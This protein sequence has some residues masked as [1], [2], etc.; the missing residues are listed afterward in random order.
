MAAVAGHN[1]DQAG[2]AILASNISKYIVPT[3]RTNVLYPVLAYMPDLSNNR[4]EKHDIPQWGTLATPANQVEADEYAFSNIPL[5][6][7]RTI[8]AVDPG[9]RALVTDQVVMDTGMSS[10]ASVNQHIEALRQHI[11]KMMFDLIN[12]ATNITDE[13]GNAL[14]LT[15][16]LDGL[17]AFK[18]QKPLGLQCFVGS[19]DQ[20]NDFVKEL[21]ASGGSPLIQGAGSEVFAG[22]GASYDGYR[23][24]YAGVRIFETANVQ[25]ADASNDAGAFFTVQPGAGPGGETLSPFA[26]GVWQGIYAKGVDTPHRKGEDVTVSSRV[27]WQITTQDWIRAFISK[28]AA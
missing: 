23:G 13:S 3:A 18:K 9:L 24:M 10:S 12:S 5:T 16:W 19:P 14:T 28:K 2:A 6:A 17:A 1:T 8:T 20:I 27:G 4:S 21:Q 15:S 25:D 26:I 11:D 7:K 22:V